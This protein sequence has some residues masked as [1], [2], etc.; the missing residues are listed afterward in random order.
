MPTLSTISNQRINKLN[1]GNYYCVNRFANSLTLHNPGL[2][3]L[4]LLPGRFIHQMENKGCNVYGT[5]QLYNHE[6]RQDSN[7][8]QTYCLSFAQ[9]LQDN[10]SYQ[11]NSHRMF[12]V[13]E[14]DRLSIHDNSM[15]ILRETLTMQKPAK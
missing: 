9:I 5:M 2:L 13:R 6:G 10:F 7:P 15:I 4:S 3:N 1:S 11:S 14:F 8:E 12:A